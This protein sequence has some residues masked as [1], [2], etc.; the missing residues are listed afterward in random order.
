MNPA[1][2]FAGS[3]L[4][5]RTAGLPSEAALRKGILQTVL[6]QPALRL[7]ERFGFSARRNF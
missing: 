7:Q 3:V 1:C 5:F 6:C 4:L 2:L